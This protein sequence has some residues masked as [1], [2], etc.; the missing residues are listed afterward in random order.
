MF[1]PSKTFKN[2]GMPMLHIKATYKIPSVNHLFLIVSNNPLKK[3]TEAS[4]KKKKILVEYLE[5]ILS[6]KDND[7]LSSEKE[8]KVKLY[9]EDEFLEA[10]R[11]NIYETNISHTF[12]DHD[13]DLLA[14]NCMTTESPDTL[15][16]TKQ[17]CYVPQD[18]MIEVVI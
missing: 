13:L 12:S 3:E 6:I 5:N 4:L 8:Y 10:L 11:T 2:S 15:V 18:D 9:R 16:T 7:E 1:F 14:M 17:L